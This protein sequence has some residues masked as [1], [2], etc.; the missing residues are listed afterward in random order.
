M[1]IV[2]SDHHPLPLLPGHRFPAAQDALL[3]ER[4]AA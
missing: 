2:V 1:T 3:R 4:V